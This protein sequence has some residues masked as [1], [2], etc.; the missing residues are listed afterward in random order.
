M[1]NL[2][3]QND[4]AGGGAFIFSHESIDVKERKDLSISINF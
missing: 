2:Y 4:R 1:I 3:R